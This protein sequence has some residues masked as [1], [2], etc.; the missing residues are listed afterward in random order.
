M[1]CSLWDRTESDMTKMTAVADDYSFFFFKLFGPVLSDF[2]LISLSMD[3]SRVKVAKYS[4][5][6]VWGP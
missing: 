1:G 2:F 5:R 4:N 6:F 3:F